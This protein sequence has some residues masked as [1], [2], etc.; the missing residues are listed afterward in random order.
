MYSTY[1][2]LWDF[3]GYSEGLDAFRFFF[4]HCVKKKYCTLMRP[5]APSNSGPSLKD[6]NGFR[7]KIEEV[8]CAYK[9]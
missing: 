3:V 9:P 1:D 7:A 5:E 8:N 4:E 2:G 6:S